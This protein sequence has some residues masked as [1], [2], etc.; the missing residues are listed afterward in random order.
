VARMTALPR[1]AGSSGPGHAGDA[2]DAGVL[3]TLLALTGISGFVDAC[4]YLGLGHVFTAN[5]TGN[6]VFL[7]FAAAGAPGFSVTASLVSLAAFLV[8]ALAGGHLAR[9]LRMSRRRWIMTC[10]GV[11]CLL[12]AEAATVAAI[13][14]V[15]GFGRY[16]IIAVMALAMGCRNA[17]VRELSVAD[18]TTTVL[19]MTLTSLA[20][21]CVLTGGSSPRTPRRVAAV[22]A[23]LTGAWLGVAV[24]RIAGPLACLITGAVALAVT[25]AGFIE[26]GRRATQAAEYRRA[27]QAAEYP[28]AQYP[29]GAAAAGRPAGSAAAGKAAGAGPATEGSRAPLSA[30]RTRVREA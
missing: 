4:S 26:A 27:K 8:G 29:A 7:G 3:P 21:D 15:A 12:V 30:E 17:T 16:A 13:I 2:G 20:A 19:T 11:E 24:L 14:G 28:F 10:I 1:S 22:A 5:M 6:V 9:A 18:M 25:M 23:M